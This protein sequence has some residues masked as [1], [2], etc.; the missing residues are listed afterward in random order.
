MIGLIPT[1]NNDPL[2]GVRGLFRQMMETG[3]VEAFYLPLEMEGGSSGAIM[4][5]LVTDP[6]YLERA[7]PFAPAMPINGARAVVELTGKHAP[8]RIGVVLRS[9]ELRALSELVKLQQANLDG[10]VLVGVDC[11]GTYEWVD[12]NRVRGNGGFHAEEYLQA[13]TRGENPSET[14][15]RAACQMCTQ[16]VPEHVDVH[17]HLFGA[18]LAKGIPVTI[19]D[20]IAER[21]ELVPAGESA[22]EGRQ[23]VIDEMISR[24]D[25]VRQRE[26]AAMRQRLEE[27]DGFAEV[28]STCIRCHNC[29][30]ACP[31]CYCKT[32]LFCTA[33][34]DHS[35]EHYLTTARRKGAMRLLGDTLLFHLT[36]LNHMGLSCVSCGMCTSACPAEIP[37]GLL[38][39]VLGGDVQA[40]FEYKPGRDL[41]E[42]LPLI[43]FQADEWTQVG[44][45]GT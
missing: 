12:Y 31:I 43:T 25:L 37:V 44:E 5:A 20:A 24:R 8:S 11:P 33:S 15:L 36:R 22:C 26:F 9:C 32:C 10:V 1:Q 42:P 19:E 28:F 6:A 13:G 35:P 41:S 23:A 45:R 34:F 21:L 4:P 18:D 38:F 29:Q 3:I 14:P 30:T 40:A 7:N 39:S 27:K 2:A 16:P 17:L